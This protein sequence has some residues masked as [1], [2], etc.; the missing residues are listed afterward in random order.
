M[1]CWKRKFSTHRMTCTS[2]K[3]GP[4]GIVMD[5]SDAECWLHESFYGYWTM[6]HEAFGL[7]SGDDI[8]LAVGQEVDVHFGA[9]G[10]VTKLTRV[11]N[12]NEGS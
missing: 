11:R 6:V 1:L 4:A 9:N 2:A 12:D 7:K 10:Q 3:I 5:F 8:A